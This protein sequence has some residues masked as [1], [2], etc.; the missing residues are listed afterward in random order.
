METINIQFQVPTTGQY[1]L[2]EFVAKLKDY[3]DIRQF[4][5][6]YL[7]D[8]LLI[9]RVWNLLHQLGEELFLWKINVKYAIFKKIL[10]FWVSFPWWT[11][12]CL[13]NL[14]FLKTFRRTLHFPAFSVYLF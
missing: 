10:S 1:T 12:K 9:F 5:I 13:K 11:A 7:H 2:D 3:A 14:N 4:Y 6:F 8:F